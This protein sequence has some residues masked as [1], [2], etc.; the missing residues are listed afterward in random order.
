MLAVK[1]VASAQWS[2]IETH[3][4]GAARETRRQR[5]TFVP[6]L[7]AFYLL[8]FAVL[9]TTVGGCASWNSSA[10]D[11][12][13]LNKK[14]GLT[15]LPESRKSVALEFEFINLPLADMVADDSESVWQ[16]VD[17]T[18]VDTVIR[19]RLLANGIRV[20]FVA[21]EQ[22]FRRRLNSQTQEQD[23][24]EQFL[25]E[26]SV[27]SDFDQGQKRVPLRM[28]RRYELPLHR[29]IPGNHVALI[30]VQDE[31]IGRTLSD[32]QY[33][34][35]I[36]AKPA[37]NQNQIQLR[38]RTEIQHGDM[39]QKWVSTDAA[40]RIDMRRETWEIPELDL[41][42]L[43]EEGS[44]IVVAPT[45]PAKGL[46]KHMLTGDSADQDL[47]QVVVLIRVAQIPTAVDLL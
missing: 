37:D 21:N 47:E 7:P 12:S 23:V 44:L 28:G 8:G 6:R 9:A 40:M 41:D 36:T 29:P 16:W 45:T 34:Y 13:E 10:T 18:R 46:G 33:L 42:L 1:V 5:M 30:R 14:A 20:G 24:V 32:A 3:T 19:Q 27:A 15:E 17:E 4:E 39:R 38:L 25:A 31:T 2:S 35:A 22:R 11:L 43:A 26:A